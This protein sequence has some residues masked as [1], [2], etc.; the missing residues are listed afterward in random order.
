MKEPKVAIITSTLNQEKTL[1][2]CLTSFKDKNSYKNFKFYFIDDS[3]SGKIALKMKS[4]FPWVGVVSNK[5]NLGYSVS[6]NTLIKKAIR[7]YDPDY[8]LHVDD[9]VEFFEKDVLKKAVSVAE[10]LPEGGIFG[11]RLVYPDK[12][13]QWFSKDGKITF[14]KEAGTKSEEDKKIFE[15]QQVD[16]VIGAFF[17]IR[18]DVVDKIGLLDEMF[19]PAYGEET[20]FCFRAAKNGF[21]MFYVGELAVIHN[22]SS[23]SKTVPSDYIWFVKKRNAIRLEWKHYGFFKILKY[24]IIHFGAVFFKRDGL[25]IWKKFR[26]LLD[27]YSFNMKNLNNIKSFRRNNGHLKS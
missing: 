6:N 5:E 20:D 11:A 19:S 13:S 9:D 15:T 24:S 14:I 7:E 22:G 27:A 2:K 3:G 25:G 4:M 23:S 26:L 21:K 12:S 17:L 16:N 1:I 10:N 8:I 18:R